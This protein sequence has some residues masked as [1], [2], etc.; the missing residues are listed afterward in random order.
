MF[1][2]CRT[3][4]QAHRRMK[5]PDKLDTHKSKVDAPI[6]IDSQRETFNCIHRDRGPTDMAPERANCN[7]GN[8]KDYADD[9]DN[10]VVAAATKQYG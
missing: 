2:Q 7:D 5:M 4:F 8:A 6:K 3:A 9:N 1:T 10:C